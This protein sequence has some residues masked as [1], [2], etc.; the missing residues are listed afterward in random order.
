[1]G[2]LLFFALLSRL[3]RT[4]GSQYLGLLPAQTRFGGRLQ[5][6]EALQL[7][8]DPQA[9]LCRTGQGDTIHTESWLKYIEHL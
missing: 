8:L 6:Y 9:M 5:S 7:G 1:M 2:F 4:D 3:G